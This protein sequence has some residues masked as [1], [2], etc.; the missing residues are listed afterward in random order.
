MFC[1][2]VQKCGSRSIRFVRSAGPQVNGF[3][4]D[5]LGGGGGE[6]EGLKMYYVYYILYCVY[7]I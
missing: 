3:L 5:T 2:C 1:I 6:G 7:Y 4:S